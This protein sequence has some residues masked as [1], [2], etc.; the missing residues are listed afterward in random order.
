MEGQAGRLRNILRSPRTIVIVKTCLYIV[1]LKCLFLKLSLI[2]LNCLL[3]KIVSG[4]GTRIINK[5]EKLTKEEEVG[6]SSPKEITDQ[7]KENQCVRPYV[8]Q[9]IFI[10]IENW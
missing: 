7:S 5:R 2:S 4:K 6:D 9:K 3:T 1:C 8:Q 10:V